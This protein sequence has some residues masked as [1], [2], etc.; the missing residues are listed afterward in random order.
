MNILIIVLIFF[1]L[2]TIIKSYKTFWVVNES[3]IR[4]RKFPKSQLEFPRLAQQTAQKSGAN[5]ESS[6]LGYRHREG[7]EMLTSDAAEKA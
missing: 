2:T 4:F 7:I 5:M 6:L 3:I 1:K